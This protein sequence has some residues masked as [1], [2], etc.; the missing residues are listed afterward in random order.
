M[1]LLR[2]AL[3]LAGLMCLSGLVGVFLPA[4]AIASM[5]AR[6]GFAAGATAPAVVYLFRLASA[7]T[8]CCGPFFLLMARDPR[9]HGALVPVG[10]AAIVFVGVVLLLT[11]LTA[12]MPLEVFLFD[13]LGCFLIGGAVVGA[14]LLRGR[15]PGE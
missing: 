15:G 8:A 5:L 14:W 7:V 11:G 10:G 12:S 4:K 3:I 1:K 9:R 2:G 6:Y 13:F